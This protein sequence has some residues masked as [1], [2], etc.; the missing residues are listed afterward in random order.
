[1]ANQKKRINKTKDRSFEIT[2]SGNKNLKKKEE[3]FMGHKRTPS[4]KTGE[5]DRKLI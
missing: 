2:Q 4:C 5:S 3:A 1:L